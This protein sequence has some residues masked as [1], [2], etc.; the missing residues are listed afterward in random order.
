MKDAGRGF[1]R[2]AGTREEASVLAAV[3]PQDNKFSLLILPCLGHLCTGDE[4]VSSQHPVHLP[5]ASILPVIVDFVSRISSSGDYT[6]LLQ[7]HVT[8]PQVVDFVIAGFSLVV[9]PLC[10]GSLTLPVSVFAD[11]FFC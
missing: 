8:L 10:F 4:W 5:S 2:W 7:S 9:L 1:Y 11:D 6:L 3:T